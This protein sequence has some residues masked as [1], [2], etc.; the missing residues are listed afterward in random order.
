MS[1]I[2]QEDG[3]T[4]PSHDEE[5]HVTGYVTVRIPVDFITKYE[6]GE[7]GFDDDLQD[8]IDFD[9]CFGMVE[10]DLDFEIVKREVE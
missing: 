9:T 6:P 1:Y 10:E 7:E 4:Y 2:N 5:Y 3:L 8:G